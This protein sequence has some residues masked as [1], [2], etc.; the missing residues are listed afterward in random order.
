MIKIEKGVI[1]K[2]NFHSL[3]FTTN[4]RVGYDEVKITKVMKH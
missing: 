2:I 3:I 1:K 4:S